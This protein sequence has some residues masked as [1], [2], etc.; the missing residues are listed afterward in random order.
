MAAEQSKWE[1]G[2]GKTIDRAMKQ[3]YA[4][5]EKNGGKPPYVVER[6]ELHGENPFTHYSV[7]IV[8]GG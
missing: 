7:F 6:I 3:A 1:P 5:A 8:P 2:Q 4:I